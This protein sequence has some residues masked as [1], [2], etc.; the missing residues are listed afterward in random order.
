M[1]LIKLASI[2]AKANDDDKCLH[3]ASLVSQVNQPLVH[4]K[5]SRFL[6]CGGMVEGCSSLMKLLTTSSV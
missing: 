5:P 2:K 1:E 3:L 6:L 4:E